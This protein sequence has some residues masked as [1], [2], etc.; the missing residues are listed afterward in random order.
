M[1][2]ECV[3]IQ[4]NINIILSVL[5]FVLPFLRVQKQYVLLQFTKSSLQFNVVFKLF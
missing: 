5:L 2:F 3:C 1:L 4:I